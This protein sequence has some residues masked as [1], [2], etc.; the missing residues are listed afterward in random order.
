MYMILCN[1]YAMT[2][3]ESWPLHAH[4]THPT[5]THTPN[6]NTHTPKH[7]YPT[8]PKTYHIFQCFCQF[9]LQFL[10]TA[11]CI[12]QLY[13]RH[14][15]LCAQVIVVLLYMTE[16]QQFCG[17]SFQ[18]T[19][20]VLYMCFQSVIV[21]FEA[22]CF[23]HCCRCACLG[24]V[25]GWYCHTHGIVKCASYCQR[26]THYLSW[27]QLFLSV[28]PSW[29]LCHSCHPWLL[30]EPWCATHQLH[31]PLR[32][33]PVGVFSVAVLPCGRGGVLDDVPTRY[34]TCYYWSVCWGGWGV[35]E[36]LLRGGCCK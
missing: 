11:C 1:V 25:C 5:K 22:L 2:C 4:S 10:H 16:L 17:G 30:L 27:R 35:E 20:Q 19:F 9:V 28:L 13:A 14:I 8:K 26:Y 6:Q 36:A 12:L 15:Q 33:A 31:H 7:T 23:C 21:G 3:M 24:V 29:I 18:S 32:L 34:L